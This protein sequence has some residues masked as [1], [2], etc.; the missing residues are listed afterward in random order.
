MVS[1]GILTLT[2]TGTI[3][4][5][6]ST[7][8]YLVQAI[9]VFQKGFPIPYCQA[10]QNWTF[11]KRTENG[12]APALTCYLVSCLPYGQRELH[13]APASFASFATP[14]WNTQISGTNRDLENERV[15]KEFEDTCPQASRRMEAEESQSFCLPR[16]L[17]VS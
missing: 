8:H 12:I 9:F 6:R 3:S 17:G 10:P 16:A 4:S 15:R 5:R 7:D 11:V 1:I 2:L 14:L 13:P